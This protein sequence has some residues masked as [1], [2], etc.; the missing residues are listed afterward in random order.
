MEGSCRCRHRLLRLYRL[1]MLSV[2]VCVRD[3]R[4]KKSSSNN[5]QTST[6]DPFRGHTVF[7]K[8]NSCKIASSDSER[9]HDEFDDVICFMRLDG[10]RRACRHHKHP[11]ACLAGT[12]VDAT[13]HPLLRACHTVMLLDIKLNDEG[14]PRRNKTTTLYWSADV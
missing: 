11:A 14:G 5:S 2:R 7:L 8:G 4:R 10:G 6:I 1:R 3:V 9:G 13:F 12:G